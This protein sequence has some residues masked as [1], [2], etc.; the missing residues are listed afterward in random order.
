MTQAPTTASSPQLPAF[1]HTPARYE[2]P[3]KQEVLDMRGH[4]VH[5]Q[6]Q[7]WGWVAGIRFSPGQDDVFRFLNRRYAAH[8]AGDDALDHD[9]PDVTIGAAGPMTLPS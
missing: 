1:D 3:S 6:R 5:T 9:S 4:V 7:P 8:T 2:G